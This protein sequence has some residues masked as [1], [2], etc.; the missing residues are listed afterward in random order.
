MPMEQNGETRVSPEPEM[1]SVFR[2][3]VQTEMAKHALEMS[4]RTW[5]SIPSHFHGWCVRVCVHTLL[6]TDFDLDL[7]TSWTSTPETKPDQIKVG[8][9]K[10]TQ[11]IYTP[12]VLN[13]SKV[14]VSKWSTRIFG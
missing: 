1:I 11:D 4:L 10:S 9:N 6:V 8:D 5:L 3:Q 13:H 7:D 2:F 12:I 14:A